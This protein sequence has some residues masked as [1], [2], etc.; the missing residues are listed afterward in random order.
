MHISVVYEDQSTAGAGQ[1]SPHTSRQLS[2]VQLGVLLQPVESGVPSRATLVSREPAIRK[3]PSA[4][5]P[6]AESLLLQPG[7][8]A[9]ASISRTLVFQS[10][11][12]LPD[13]RGILSSPV[14]HAT[15]GGEGRRSHLEGNGA[16]GVHAQP[17]YGP[18][19][20]TSPRGS[21]P[22]NCSPILSGLAERV[23]ACK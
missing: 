10:A 3:L 13:P 9:D 8:A 19:G 12:F 18:L 17:T 4:A 11:G 6:R 14:V 1:H 7:G 2:D 16:S 20:G 23:F 5:P 21:Q 15:A 22:T